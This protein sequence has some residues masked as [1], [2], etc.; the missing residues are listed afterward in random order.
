MKKVILILCA[1]LW[2]ITVCAQASGGQIVRKKT[3]NVAQSPNKSTNK[4]QFVVTNAKEFL[5][6]IGSNREIIVKTSTPIDLTDEMIKRLNNGSVIEHKLEK[7]VPKGL[8]ADWGM[9]GPGVVFAGLNNLTI[10]GYTK[11][12]KI[13][14][15]SYECAV[16]RLSK[17]S[18]LKFENL[19]LGHNRGTCYGPVIQV[20]T[21]RE[22]I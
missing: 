1:I 19:V 13:T 5:D 4:K 16:I 3:P 18:N 15:E 22:I 7:S 20:D 12:T 21:C 11:N 2:T 10:K 6:A 9:S 8:Y 17:C 14:V